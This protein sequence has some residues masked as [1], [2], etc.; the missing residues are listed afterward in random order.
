M[1]IRFAKRIAALE[2]KVDVPEF[3]MGSTRIDWQCLS[4]HER[5][6]FEKLEKL[7][8]EYGNR[9]EDI[10]KDVLAENLEAISKGAEVIFRRVYDLFFTAM[11]VY[12][13]DDKFTK[14]IFLV[15]FNAFLETTLNIVE[16]RKREEKF[17]Q[18][19]EE[20][21]GENWPDNIGQPD[22][23]DIGERDF[24]KALETL[25][26]SLPIS[27]SEEEQSEDDDD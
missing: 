3:E 24:N 23:S 2:S 4:G 27:S 20:K 6:L 18:Q 8:E 21:Y 14:W 25:V 15:R 26:S 5:M 1:S 10:P 17:Y 19:V 16:M 12:T 13:G 22:L 11:E 7:S 9:F